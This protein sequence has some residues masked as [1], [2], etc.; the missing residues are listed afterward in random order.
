MRL[1]CLLLILFLSGCGGGAVVFAPTPLPPDLSP[2]RY[3][4][5]SGT[6]SLSVPRNWSVYVQ[7]TSTLA[8]VTFSPPNSSEPLL[9]AAV[10]RTQAPIEATAFGEMMEQYQT[11]HRPDLRYYS[12]QD[13]QAM[14]DGSWRLSGYRTTAGGTPQGINTFF[15]F[16][17]SFVGVI[18]VVVSRDAALQS[19][20]QTA[21]NTF[22]VNPQADLQ[23]SEL[24]TLS[25]VRRS[26]LEVQ[27]VSSWMNS[28]GVFF[29]TG[30]I[31]NHGDEPL[32][33]VPVRVSLLAEN[34]TTVIEAVDVAMG[35]GIPPGGFA[36]FSLRFGEGQPTSTT[37]FNVTV[38]DG[39]WA[40][41]PQTFYG[42]GTLEWTDES[43]FADDGALLISGEVT[44]NSDNPINEPIGV[45]TVFDIEGKVIGAW[46]ASIGV[47]TI[48]PEETVEFSI[49]VPEIGGDPVNY[50]LDI[51]GVA[52]GT[53]E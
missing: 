22:R 52:N 37:A 20:L 39:N 36:P 5:P 18:D 46:F 19:E 29:V 4:H 14:G 1:L 12:E 48:Q 13:R 26:R 43:T 24:S 9:T 15:E 32:S 53:P 30:E 41:T 47:Q 42:A 25:F 2:L 35:Y 8:S 28:V 31:A 51:Q 40:A 33:N 38:G 45:V 27:N 6:F 50:I 23:A 49:R 21:I 3:E 16:A 11:T 44:N 7:N 34:G 10:I 17:G